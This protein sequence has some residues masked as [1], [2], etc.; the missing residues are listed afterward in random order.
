MAT[1]LYRVGRFAYRRKAV[2][3][4]V[5]LALLILAGVGAA[6]LSGPTSNAF[7]IPGTPAQQALDL[8]SERFPAA[9]EDPLTAATAQY[10]FQAP[11]G[12][13]LDSPQ[14]T[15]AIDKVIADIRGIAAVKDSAKV[16][17]AAGPFAVPPQTSPQNISAPASFAREL[18]AK[19]VM[20]PCASC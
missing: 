5:W 18:M 19:F 10:V 2:V 14:N 13:T 17:P 1:Y 16:D 3:L 11:A 12:T 9:S 7:S 15:A 4:V 8:Q 20:S 6:T